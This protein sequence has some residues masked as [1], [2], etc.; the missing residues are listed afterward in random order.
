MLHGII[1]EQGHW[2]HV[3]VDISGKKNEYT[4]HVFSISL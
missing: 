2:L 1:N 3:R 4:L